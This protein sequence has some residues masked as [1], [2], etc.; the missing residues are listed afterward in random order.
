MLTMVNRI[1]FL[2]HSS[3]VKVTVGIIDKFGVRGMLRF[4]LLYLKF[5]YFQSSEG[6]SVYE[7]CVDTEGLEITVEEY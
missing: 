3:N 6:H 2:G 5:V 7:A 1:D 4:A